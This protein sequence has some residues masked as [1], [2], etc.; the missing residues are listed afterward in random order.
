MK[1]S[2]DFGQIEEIAS[3]TEPRLLREIKVFDVYEGDRIEADKKAYAI[4][5]ILQ[6]R[7]KTLTDKVIDKSMSRLMKAFESETGA[8]I[9]Q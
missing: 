4:S 3:K 8:M 6:D 5:F 9:R 2:I 7:E 1:K